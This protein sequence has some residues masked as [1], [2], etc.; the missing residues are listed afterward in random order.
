MK[1]ATQI[2]GK[3]RRSFPNIVTD[4]AADLLMDQE[5]EITKL[6]FALTKIAD[7]ND[8]LTVMKSIARQ[9]LVKQ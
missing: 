7:G 8:P 9:A 2:A 1:K 6:R 5:L 4:E 3:L